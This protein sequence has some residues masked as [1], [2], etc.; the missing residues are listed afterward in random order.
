MN[1]DPSNHPVKHFKKKTVGKAKVIPQITG[2]ICQPPIDVK[3]ILRE[4]DVVL[5]TSTAISYLQK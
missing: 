3:M 1:M 2:L 4:I 5:P